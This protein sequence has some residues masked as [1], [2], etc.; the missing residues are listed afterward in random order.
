MREFY[1]G[2]WSEVVVLVLKLGFMVL[3]IERICITDAPFSRRAF[4]TGFRFS[5]IRLLILVSLELMLL[6]FLALR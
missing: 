2:C 3:S 6:L 5:Y 1:L 4:F